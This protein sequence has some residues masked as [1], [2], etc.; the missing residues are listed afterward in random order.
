MCRGSASRSEEIIVGEDSLPPGDD[1]RAYPSRPSSSL[2]TINHFLFFLSPISFGF[3]LTIQL[4]DSDWLIMVRIFS[5]RS[6]THSTLLWS[7]VLW[8]GSGPSSPQKAPCNTWQ[9]STR[10]RGRRG[11]P[12]EIDVLRIGTATDDKTMDNLDRTFLSN[13]GIFQTSPKRADSYWAI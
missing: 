13:G 4:D 6:N 1:A 10:T 3:P 8:A 7:K 11:M 9:P 2:L 12:L 5:M